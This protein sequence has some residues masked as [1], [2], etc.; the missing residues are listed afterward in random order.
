MDADATDH[1]SIGWEWVAVAGVDGYEAQF[2]TSQPFVDTDLP[3]PT[4]PTNP[5][6]HV[7]HNLAAETNGYLQVRSV[8]GNR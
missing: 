5:T 2:S 3:S 7:V 1:D 6:S 4:F 8:I